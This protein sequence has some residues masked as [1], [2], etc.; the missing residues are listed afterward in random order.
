MYTAARACVLLLQDR[1][2]PL[3][4]SALC[5]VQNSVF[6][7]LLLGCGLEKQLAGFAQPLGCNASSQLSALHQVRDKRGQLLTSISP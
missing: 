1:D 2:K 6:S 3:L 5:L 7:T 4:Y